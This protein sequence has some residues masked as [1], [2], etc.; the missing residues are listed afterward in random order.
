MKTRCGNPNHVAYASYGS[1]GISVCERWLHSFEN[2]LNDMGPR[3]SKKYTLDRI[4]NDDNYVPYNCQ[5][6]TREVQANNRRERE[7]RLKKPDMLPGRRI[8]RRTWVKIFGSDDGYDN[9]NAISENA[10]VEQ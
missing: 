3:P 9:L 5:W 1:R 2:F 7:K 10:G 8:S 4:D 6:A